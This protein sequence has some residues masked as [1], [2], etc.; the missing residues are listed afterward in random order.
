MLKTAELRYLIKPI[1]IATATSALL[2]NFSALAQQSC[3]APTPSIS[4][5][6]PPVDVA[7]GSS[8]DQCG[9]AST[10]FF[11]DFSWRSFIALIWPAA[12]SQRGVPDPAKTNFPVGGALVFETY[13]NSTETLLIQLRPTLRRSTPRNAPAKSASSG[14]LLLGRP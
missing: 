12:A 14:T 8:V 9:A 10:K 3:V 6:T 11:D 2:L 13:T 7:N 5:P 1:A 4:S